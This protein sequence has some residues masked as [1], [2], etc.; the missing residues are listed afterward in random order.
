MNR[1]NFVPL[2]ARLRVNNGVNDGSGIGGADF[3][4]QDMHVR[5]PLIFVDEPADS[6]VTAYM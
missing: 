6:E 4:S 1:Y 2:Y 3:G 5:R